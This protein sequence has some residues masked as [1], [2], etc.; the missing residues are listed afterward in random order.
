[1]R[2]LIVDSDQELLEILQ[3]FM[4][5]CGH[6]AE[7]ATNGLE[8]LDILREFP[9][10]V[11]VLEEELLWGGCE[12]ILALMSEDPVLNQIPTILIGDDDPHRSLSLALRK[13]VFK[14]LRKP[15]PLGDLEACIDAAGRSAK[16]LHTMR[17]PVS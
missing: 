14:S 17:L 3:S 13:Q 1:M 7:V 5:K 6:E 12:N 10:E 9:P 8:C 11:L 16:A 15:F 2:V 4:S